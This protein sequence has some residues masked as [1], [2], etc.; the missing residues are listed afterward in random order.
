MS[1]KSSPADSACRVGKFASTCDT[2]GAMPASSRNPKGIHQSGNEARRLTAKRATHA[3][4]PYTQPS[5]LPLAG[6]ERKCLVDCST[7]RL[8]PLL[9]PHIRSYY[10]RLR[11]P[12]LLQSV[13]VSALGRA[14][15]N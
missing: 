8:V 11:V 2:G 10:T 15:R 3:G 9:V 7:L 14:C 4:P 12:T 5:A 6:P 13:I 1:S